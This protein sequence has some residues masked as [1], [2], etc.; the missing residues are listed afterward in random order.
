M[1]SN[2]LKANLAQEAERW[3]LPEVNGSHVV[4]ATASENSAGFRKKAGAIPSKGIPRAIT[5]SQLEQ[6][7][8]EAQSAAEVSGREEG[9]QRGYSEGQQTANSLLEQS[10]ER[11]DKLVA[12]VTDEIEEEKKNLQAMFTQLL[13]RLCSAVCLKELAIESNIEEIVSR[14]LAALPLSE[15]Q[16]TV[17][18]NPA[19]YKI[20][21]PSVERQQKWK[22]EANEDV[23]VG[24][25]KVS[26]ENSEID[27]TLQQRVSQIAEQVF[28]EYLSPTE[29]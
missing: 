26:S 1:A 6:I 4:S 24:G 21:A 20:L 8:L 10:R 23:L 5:A 15:S 16:I 3:L 7:T 28:E 29:D 12:S 25:C 13:I 14:A 9:Y 27:F 2:V 17:Y 19:D 18:L 22:L 11:I